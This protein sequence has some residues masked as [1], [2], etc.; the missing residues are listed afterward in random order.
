MDNS[1]DIKIDNYYKRNKKIILLLGVFFAVILVSI[2]FIVLSVREK[3]KQK[4]PEATQIE[5]QPKGNADAGSSNKIPASQKDARLFMFFE[6]SN[7]LIDKQ[8]FTLP[9]DFYN[10][11]VAGIENSI[12][13]KN[14]NLYIIR[15]TDGLGASELWRYG[16]R[17][18]FGRTPEGVRLYSGE[19]S[20]FSVSAKGKYI[21]ITT[22]S[23][24]KQLIIIDQDGSIMKEYNTKDLEYLDERGEPFW[25]DLW[26]WTVDEK[27]FW[28]TLGNKPIS[29]AVFKI[30]SSSWEISKYNV[31]FDQEWDLN[32]N[33]KKIV[34]SDCPVIRDSDTSDTFRSSETKV[35][36]MIYDIISSQNST[37]ETAIAK[38]FN[39]KW[40]NG[41]VIEYNNPGGNGRTSKIIGQ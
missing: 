13:Y 38:C 28:G 22:A 30:S 26:D 19:I 12:E 23:D 15:R 39:P 1:Q 18:S 41:Q 37:L 29:E 21:A 16:K 3:S 11:N 32:V 10:E 4:N 34:Y 2:S 25:F 40:I 6:D 17:D 5:N 24:K 31:P 36:L 8:L 14:D 9:N 33:S 35:N 20:K 7:K 27:E